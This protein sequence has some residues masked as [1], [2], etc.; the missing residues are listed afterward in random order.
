[1]TRINDQVIGSIGAEL[2]NADVI[3]SGTLNP[4]LQPV[5]NAE[6]FRNEY[7]NITE[8]AVPDGLADTFVIIRIRTGFRY[9][10]DRVTWH[11]QQPGAEARLVT[12]IDRTDPSVADFKIVL[13]NAT[14]PVASIE[15]V[16]GVMAQMAQTLANEQRPG[17]FI[18]PALAELVFDLRKEGGGILEAGAQI[19][20]LFGERLPPERSWDRVRANTV[21]V[22]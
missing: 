9:R 20:T 3:Q 8:S 1:M 12:A 4:T 19:L 11:N 2:Q 14:L 6:E 7:V 5:L 17:P 22:G 21:L 13:G 18:V 16:V 15:P 10:V